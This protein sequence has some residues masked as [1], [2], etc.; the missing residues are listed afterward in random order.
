MAS[1][2]TSNIVEPTHAN[3]STGCS[4]TPSINS[5]RTETTEETLIGT[6]A[7][8]TKPA[9]SESSRL[10]PSM[11]Y[12][13]HSVRASCPES[14]L[15]QRNHKLHAKGHKT[16]PFHYEWN[17]VARSNSGGRRK[18][19]STSADDPLSVLNDSTRFA[20]ANYECSFCSAQEPTFKELLDH[21]SSEHPWYDMSIHRNIR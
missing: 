14:L 19:S 10:K 21:I 8:D 11:S 15:L 12:T 20:Q 1:D 18:S 9:K 3:I 13:G 4:R 16:P 2:F 7:F 5:A 17:R 6:L